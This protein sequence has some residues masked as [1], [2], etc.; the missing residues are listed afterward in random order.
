MIH[1]STYLL[2]RNIA[3]HSKALG[4]DL[5]LIVD[6]GF[7]ESLGRP[8]FVVGDRTTTTTAISSSRLFQS[9]LCASNLLIAI[10]QE[11]GI[12]LE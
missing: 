10:E 7:H 2:V 5:V 4:N 6:G 12:A 1:D 9:L 11:G 8:Q 3:G